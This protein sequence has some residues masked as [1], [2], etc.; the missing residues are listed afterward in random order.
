VVHVKPA[1]TIGRH[2]RARLARATLLVVVALASL[3]IASFA[4][5]ALLVG[6]NFVSRSRTE[7]AQLIAGGRATL[8]DG[9]A[10]VPTALQFYALH[11]YLGFVADPASAT[12]PVRDS[13]G[14]MVPTDLGFFRRR[15]DIPSTT[16]HPIRIGVFGGSVAFLFSLKADHLLERAVRASPVAAGRD[17]VVQSFALPGYKQPQQLFALLYALLSGQHFDVVVNIDGFNELVLPL[18]ENVPQA[19]APIY[20]RSWAQLVS[21]APPL[22]LVE[23]AARAIAI[24]DA[25]GLLARAFDLP[26]V[27]LSPTA[28]LLWRALDRE[29]ARRQAE[30]EAALARWSSE[31]SGYRAHGPAPAVTGR[32][33]MPDLVE[34]WRNSSLLMHRLCA[35][36]GIAY[37]HVLQPN[38]YVPGA[39]PFDAAERRIAHR[40]DHPYRAIVERGYPQLVQAGVSLRDAGVRFED[41]S[42]MFADRHE[43]LFIDDCCHFNG[44]GNQLLATRVADA[45]IA[46]LSGSPAAP[47]SP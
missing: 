2:R 16:D 3:E 22:A 30:S 26:L 6:P 25:R 33:V 9:A 1:P 12:G 41:A 32:D 36:N 28:N 5:G 40:D 11:P 44:R 15:L 18:T 42:L 20:P 17:V 8:P 37:V 47:R 7:R 4:V 34:L 46:A 24:G 45:V 19:T 14:G 21:T 27:G 29:L 13:L 39:K 43:P 35:A 23:R 31:Q 38:Q 10:E